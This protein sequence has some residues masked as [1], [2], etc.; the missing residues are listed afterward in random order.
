MTL[1]PPFRLLG[2]A[3]SHLL[4]AYNAY[5]TNTYF[6]PLIIFAQV[7]PYQR[8]LSKLKEHF[9]HHQHLWH[10][11]A[12]TMQYFEF[13]SLSISVSVR[14]KKKNCI[15]E[16]IVSYLKAHKVLTVLTLLCA[17]NSRNQVLLWWAE[18]IRHK[19]VLQEIYSSGAGTG[20]WWW[21]RKREGAWGAFMSFRWVHQV[22][23]RGIGRDW[24]QVP[25]GLVHETVTDDC[26][27]MIGYWSGLGE[28]PRE[29]VVRIHRW[30]AGLH[31]IGGWGTGV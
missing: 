14:G 29:T 11:Y 23:G 16:H 28:G 13:S 21:A 12:E 30:N 19:E 17:A 31:L 24:G 22:L 18:D 1:D 3:V 27:R 26:L 25:R 5:S 20:R 10:W 4:S 9:P 2:S 15:Q 6:Q 8:C 7:K